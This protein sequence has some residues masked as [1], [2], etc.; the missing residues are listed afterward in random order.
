[1]SDS[2]GRLAGYAIAGYEI[3]DDEFAIL[4]L[5]TAKG[6]LRVARELI[7]AVCG[8]AARR[9]CRVDTFCQDTSHYSGFYDCLGFSRVPRSENSEIIMAFPLRPDKMARAAWKPNA[10]LRR[11]KVVAWTPTQSVALNDPESARRI[12]ALEMKDDILTRLLMSRVDVIGAVK[13]EL[14]TTT[15]GSAKDIKA[16]A[17]SLPYT[18]WEYLPIDYI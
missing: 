18:S 10:A 17:S 3:S 8:L 6:D 11:V 9:R 13:Q 14:I 7:L 2:K 1:M 15:G 4:E 5:A 16:I 12:I